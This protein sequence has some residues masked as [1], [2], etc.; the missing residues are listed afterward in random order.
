MDDL[1]SRVAA[2]AEVEEYLQELDSCIS[3]PDLK[4]DGY[5]NGLQVAINELKGLPSVDAVPVVHGRWVEIDEGDGDYTYDCSLCGFKWFLVDGTPLENGMKYCP[6][7]GAKMDGER[8]DD[9]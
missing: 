1:I 7:C 2:I 4:L 5:K 3:E 9:E 6:H 8:M